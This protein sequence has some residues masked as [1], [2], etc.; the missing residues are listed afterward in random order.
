[1]KCSIAGEKRGKENA[2][3]NSNVTVFKKNDCPTA[4]FIVIV[5][6]TPGKGVLR[7]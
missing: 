3:K 7:R 2:T 6:G 5:I 4:I 1:M